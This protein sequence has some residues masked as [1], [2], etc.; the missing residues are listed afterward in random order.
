MVPEQEY[1]LSP[2]HHQNVIFRRARYD[3]KTTLFWFISTHE[4]RAR[5]SLHAA[6]SISPPCKKNPKWSTTS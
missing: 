4:A 1:N 3:S 6:S 5:S 2:T